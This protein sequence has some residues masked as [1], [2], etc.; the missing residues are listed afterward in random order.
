L[1]SSIT[2]ICSVAISLDNTKI[3]FST[4]TQYYASTYS[5]I[6]NTWSTPNNFYSFTS[7]S[8][9]QVCISSDGTRVIT[10]APGSPLQYWTWST[11]D[12]NPISPK[13]IVNSNSANNVSTC[14]TPDGSKVAVC[15]KSGTIFNIF[16]YDV[17]TATYIEKTLTS[18]SGVMPT[19]VI[20]SG[21]SMDAS[22]NMYLS[23]NTIA[24]IYQLTVF[25]D[26]DT[27]LWAPILT[28]NGITNTRFINVNS[29]ASIIFISSDNGCY[30]TIKNT[31]GT[32]ATPI[33][34]DT[35][36]GI[37]IVSKQY[38]LLSYDAKSIY[39][40]N[41]STVNGSVSS[42]N[43]AYLETI[44]TILNTVVNK[45]LD[46]PNSF[47]SSNTID[48]SS[49]ITDKIAVTAMSADNTKLVFATTS[50][51]YYFSTYS[52]TAKRW[53]TPTFLLTS[54]LGDNLHVVISRD[55]TK[56]LTVGD[57][58]FI[59]YYN[60]T[61]S[62]PTLQ[63]T[64][65][66]TTG[67]IFTLCI[68][69]GATTFAVL[70]FT[71][72]IGVSTYNSLTD[73]Y[74]TIVF[75]TPISGESVI[76]TLNAMFWQGMSMDASG[77]LYV[78]LYAYSDAINVVCVNYNY[79]ANTYTSYICINNLAQFSNRNNAVNAD[80]SIMI[81]TS[82]SWAPY[83]IIKNIDGSYKPPVQLTTL[84]AGFYAMMFSYDGLSVFYYGSATGK[85]YY[86]N[87]AYTTLP[88]SY[89][90]SSTGLTGPAG[91]IGPAGPAGTGAQGATGSAGATGPA[92]ADGPQGATG[93]GSG[94]SKSNNAIGIS[95][96]GSAGQTGQADYAVAI[97]YYAGQNTQSTQSVAIGNAA[98]QTSQKAQSVAIGNAAGQNN[99]RELSVAIGSVAG[100]TNQGSTC[101]AIGSYAGSN[102][103]KNYTIAI[104]SNAGKTTQGTH[105]VAIGNAA[106]QNNQRDLSVAIG[107]LAGN[108]TQ[109]SEAVAIGS[110]AGN[111]TQGSTS[112]AIGSN[113]GNTTQGSTS[114]AIGSNAGNTNQGTYAVAIGSNAGLNNQPANSIVI[115]ASNSTTIGST[116]PGIS[117]N[118]FY[119]A[120]IRNDLTNI[121]NNLNYNTVTSEITYTAPLTTTVSVNAIGNLVIENG[122][123]TFNV[124]YN[125][126]IFNPSTSFIGV[127]NFYTH[128]DTA[129]G[130]ASRL[131]SDTTAIINMGISL[132]NKRVVFCTCKAA[133]YMSRTNSTWTVPV[134]F[135]TYSNDT[136][137][138]NDPQSFSG[139][140]INAAGDVVMVTTN[141]TSINIYSWT[142]TTFSEIT[143]VTVTF[144][145]EYIKMTP[146]ASLV[147]VSGYITDNNLGYFSY[148]P[149][150]KVAS[151]VTNIVTLSPC[152][153]AS[154][155]ASGS[156]IYFTSR[157]SGVGGVSKF[158][159]DPVTSIY[160]RVKMVALQSSN[161][162]HG[163]LVNSDES[164]FILQGEQYSYNYYSLDVRF[165]TPIYTDISLP[166]DRWKTITLSYDNATLYQCGTPDLTNSTIYS[167][168]INH[169]GGFQI[170]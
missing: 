75:G 95:Y 97:G 23:A 69:P 98:G 56:I 12:P 153:G 60:W 91:A 29:D 40:Q 33:L 65:S 10:N 132:N 89:F 157:T 27:Y 79:I 100:Q 159:F 112:I 170:L 26:L 11:L 49:T 141:T 113:A 104:G 131:G 115:N 30:F 120:P 83:Y 165:S 121:S 158:T 156:N 125:P 5:S 3:V 24:T 150:S 146:T 57:P 47:K 70:Y 81:I 140:C 9:S 45:A 147:V 22:G 14:I 169:S 163:C 64:I 160:N 126:K 149:V 92:G 73:M 51:V 129:T 155:N 17:S 136:N 110:N 144:I 66:V 114:I 46:I 96:D 108:T 41:S 99:Q 143:T 16:T 109:G 68:D 80:A 93:P 52:A 127:N 58:A 90:Y 168:P 4:L 50:G 62:T 54:T 77:K 1:L 151:A 166:A 107:L 106:G 59:R 148:D 88:P 119:V 94:I 2:N 43:I 15:S 44:N 111:T 21:I 19:S 103:Q 145:P 55:G 122:L 130:V 167:T 139:V 7:A 35:T 154:P 34:I 67:S 102:D 32:Y 74:S 137:I 135:H 116:G 25:Y 42:T 164:L 61:S 8:P 6:T 84:P 101:I 20:Y 152:G 161:Y 117:A 86:T 133:Y 71:K 13:G 76:E 85:I 142:D 82:E 78:T 36:S 31:T 105:S 39:F 37:P 28:S 63:Q 128:V 53:T 48:F 138:K 124:S 118:A 87:I 162:F 18:N 123:Q 134:Q 38:V 72:K